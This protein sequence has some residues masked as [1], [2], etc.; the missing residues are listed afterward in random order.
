VPTPQELAAAVEGGRD[1][2]A[3]VHARAR[4]PVALA[5]PF[6]GYLLAEGDSWFDYP[7]F[8]DVIEALEEDHGYKVSSAAHAGDTVTSMAYDAVQLRRLNDRFRDMKEAGRKPRAIL[9]SGGGN[10]VVAAL[11]VILNHRASGLPALNASV[12]AGVLQEQIPLAIASLIGSINGFSQQH[13][14]EL[15]PV[16]IHGYAAPMPDGRGYPLLGLAGPWLKPA[17]AERGWVSQDPQPTPELLANAKAI[18]DLIELFNE[19]VLPQVAAAAGANVGYVDVRAAL[20]SDL[21]V[22]EQDW[23]D[24]MHATKSGFKAVAAL[25]DSRI[26][27]VAP[28]IP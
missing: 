8:E 9:V 5:A 27:A 3:A 13:F 1:R 25:I 4:R 24:E 7:L 19:G 18:G 2:A 11:R 26:R 22:Y 17:F 12:A 6:A 20:R 10:D 16:L 23:R 21:A 15:R 14:G 28:T